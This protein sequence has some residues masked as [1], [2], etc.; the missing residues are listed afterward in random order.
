MA[1]KK[2]LW[3]EQHQM[4]LSQ[5]VSR[6]QPPEQYPFTTMFAPNRYGIING[7]PTTWHSCGR[8]TKQNQTYPLYEPPKRRH[9]TMRAT[10]TIKEDVPDDGNPR[11]CPTEPPN[12]PPIRKCMTS[13]EQQSEITTKEDA[14]DDKDLLEMPVLQG[15]NSSNTDIPPASQKDQ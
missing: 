4:T 1:K 2:D 11:T 9:R 3:L 15:S 10:A 8:A 5:P 7:R 14:S 13:H 12:V 6:E